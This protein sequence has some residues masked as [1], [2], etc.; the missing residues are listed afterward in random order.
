MA[1]LIG[2]MVS[3]T[4]RAGTRVGDAAGS[5]YDIRCIYTPLETAFIAIY[6][7]VHFVVH[8]YDARHPRIALYRYPIVAAPELQRIG[9]LACSPAVGKDAIATLG[10]QFYAYTLE[11]AHCP[12]VVE[13]V[14][15]RREKLGIG[16]HFL[17]KL[18]GRAGIRQ[19]TTAFTRNTY[20]SGRFLHFLQQQHSRAILC[21]SACRDKSRSTCA[22]NYQI[23]IPAFHNSN[24]KVRKSTIRNAEGFFIPRLFPIF[25]AELRNTTRLC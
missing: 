9:Y 23:V 18:F 2:E 16:S 24:A 14:E 12:P 21:S 8:G 22:Y 7:A 3:V 13:L 5:Y 15:S 4:S 6:D 19:I 20:F 1:R 25:V 11:E 10:A 17:G